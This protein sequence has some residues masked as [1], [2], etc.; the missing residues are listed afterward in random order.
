MNTYHT[1]Y[2]YKEP[3][4]MKYKVLLVVASIVAFIV[5]QYSFKY[6]MYKLPDILWTLSTP[7]VKLLQ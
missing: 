5:M 2:K 7:L 1:V 4:S 6:V 3:L